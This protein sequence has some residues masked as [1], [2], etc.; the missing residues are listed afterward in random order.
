MTTVLFRN[1]SFWNG[2]V[3]SPTFDGMLVEDGKIA[4]IGATAL[5]S[6]AD[7]VVDLA[8]RFVMPSFADGH[9]HPL[10]G[11]REAFGPQVTG[12]HT[13]DAVVAAVA[14]FSAA[15]PDAP[16]IVGAPGR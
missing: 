15:H 13:I 16:W 6:V 3:G 8:G 11:G 2:R 12:L 4:A 1:G 9:A 14:E 5:S 10:F 7:E